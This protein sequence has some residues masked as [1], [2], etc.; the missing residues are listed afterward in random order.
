MRPIQ[1]I[2]TCAALALL[3][4]GCKASPPK[5]DTAQDGSGEEVAARSFNIRYVTTVEGLKTGQKV[6]LWIPIPSD[7]PHQT[8]GEIA[9]DAA[10]SSRTTVEPRFGNRM[11]YFEGLASSPTAEIS[12][13]YDVARRDNVADLPALVSDGQEDA[14]MALHLESS[15]LVVVDDR[16][17][18]IA[19]ESSSGKT[20]TLAKA[21][22]F[23]DRVLADMSYDKSGEG[24]G[25]GDSLFACEVGKGNCT[26][27][28]A[29][30]MALC[31][32]EKIPSR[33]QI[34]L[35]GHYDKRPGQE[36]ETG[37]YHCWAEFRVPGKAWVPV[38]ISE[39]DKDPSRADF[40]FGGHTDNRVTVSLGR[41]L[42]LEPAQAGEPL[43]YFVQPYA[44]ANG[45]PATVSKVAYWID[46]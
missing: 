8:I 16:I 3:L 27:F 15:K 25:R 9:V 34:G 24:W 23:Y 12:V 21:R 2:V 36:Y 13:S 31:L 39:A 33:F 5:L 14:D 4:P 45:M 46:R 10:W 11:L 17:Q 42:V 32:A 29:Y 44:E 20:G 19:T 22:A 43:N 6:R 26:D 38:D 28:H 40:L 7:D 18:G 37:G 1:T 35:F 41:D 30:F